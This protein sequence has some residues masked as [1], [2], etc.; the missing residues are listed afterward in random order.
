[1]VLQQGAGTLTEAGD[2]RSRVS[3]TWSS[4]LLAAAAAAAALG[5]L[6]VAAAHRGASR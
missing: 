3:D 6:A 1:M 2:W 5:V 4:G